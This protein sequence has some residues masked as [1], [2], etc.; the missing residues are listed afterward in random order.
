MLISFRAQ[1]KTKRNML[2]KTCLLIA[3]GLLGI[4]VNVCPLR[5]Q[6]R[7]RNPEQPKRIELQKEPSESEWLR[8][9]LILP[10]QLESPLPDLKPLKPFY[11]P[12][13]DWWILELVKVPIPLLPTQE[14]T[15]AENLNRIREEAI[16]AARE[17]QL[18]LGYQ[19]PNPASQTMPMT[20]ATLGIPI[21]DWSQSAHQIKPA[22]EIPRPIPPA[23][24][25]STASDYY[26][27]A[28]FFIADQRFI[29]ALHDLNEAIRLQPDFLN[30]IFTRAELYFRLENFEL[31]V[32]D[33]TR[34]LSLKAHDELYV[35][36]A[37]AFKALSRYKEA[38]ADYQSALSLNP[39]NEVAR[40][41]LESLK[42]STN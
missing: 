28:Q 15:V 38:Q 6:E 16:R 35:R 4:W 2:K 30:A 21:P 8:P 20:T 18:P 12:P 23:K 14:Q 11:P 22:D 33:Y 9:K 32:E 10:S 27:W 31:A 17:A 41:A 26:A 25:P 37:D 24:M 19:T 1:R 7:P 5:A 29:G 3:I 36:R 34:A 13:K 42:Q 40:A 39:K